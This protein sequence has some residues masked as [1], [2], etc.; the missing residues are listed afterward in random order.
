MSIPLKEKADQMLEMFLTINEEFRW[1]HNL[2][3]HF[4]A[5]IYM[6]KKKEFDKGRI[7]NVIK[8]IKENTGM[9]S[10]YRGN[11]MFILAMLLCSEFNNPEEKFMKMLE[12]DKKLRKAGFKNSQYLAI[13]NYTL[14]LTCEDS[15]IDSRITKAYEIYREMRKNH[16]WL[17]SGDDYPLS[18][19]IAGFDRSVNTIE[20]YYTKLNQEGFSKGNGLQLLSHI[21]SFSN[22]EVE[23]TV[24][25]CKRL[26]DKLRENRLKI[27]SNYYAALGLI[28]LLEDNNGIVAGDLIE[29]SRY[30]NSLKKYKWLGKG[31][32]VLLASAMVSEKYIKEKEKTNSLIDTTINISIETLIA[33]QTSALIAG[34]TA[35]VAVSSSAN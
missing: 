30:L 27:Y 2:S 17:T 20:E 21:L 4:A 35:S 33:A 12:Y 28:S 14:L 8:V 22:E 7:D 9:F 10:C 1:Q 24:K 26:Y 3:K 23:V 29:L 18:I 16:P 13:A 32:N 11:P 15:L 34:M 6:Q 25:R 19:L 31:M 5:L